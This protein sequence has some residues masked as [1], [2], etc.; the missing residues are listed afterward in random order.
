MNCVWSHLSNVAGNKNQKEI[1][2]KTKRY[3]AT[4]DWDFLKIE[5][6]HNASTMQVKLSDS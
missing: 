4:K 1:K 6:S 5:S 3:Q 2:V